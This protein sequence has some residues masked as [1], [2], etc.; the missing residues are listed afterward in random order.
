MPLEILELHHY[1]VRVGANRKEAEDAAAFYH[2]VLGLKS[3]SRRPDLPTVPGAWIDVEGTTQVH[4]IG[5]EGDSSFLQGPG[6]DP[7]RPH[8]AFAVP[9][10]QKALQELDRM[11]V[12]YWSTKGVAGPNLIQVYFDDPAGNMIEIHQIGTCMCQSRTPIGK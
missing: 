4:L 5:V 7:T 8:I 3:D 11:G 10:I 12:P 9:D 1:A 6:Q 2:E